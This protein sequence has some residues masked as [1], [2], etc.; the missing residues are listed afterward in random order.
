MTAAFPPPAQTWSLRHLTRKTRMHVWLAHVVLC[1]EAAWRATRLP[2]LATLAA[3]VAALFALP[4]ALPGTLRVGMLVA[5]LCWWAWVIWRARRTLL[6]S[7]RSAVRRVETDAQLTCGTLDALADGITPDAPIETH[8]L[9]ALAVV[10]LQKTIGTLPWARPALSLRKHERRYIFPLLFV[11]ALAGLWT[12]ENPLHRL[13]T[14][15]SPWATSLD[16]VTLTAWL[17]PP[18]YTGLPPRQIALPVG[19]GTEIEVPANSRLVLT[20]SGA[21]ADFRLIGPGIDMRQTAQNN[22]A[23]FNVLLVRGAYALRMGSLRPVSAWQVRITKDGAPRIAFDGAVRTS[24]TQS[25][26]I[27][28]KATDDYGITAVFLA[29]LKDNKA[30]AVA[31]PDPA[32]GTQTSGRAF[33]DLTASRHAGAGVQL[34]LVALD[35]AGTYGVSAPVSLTLP[36]RKFTHVVAQQIIAARKQVWAAPG[37]LVP[38]AARLEAVSRDPAAFGGDLTI[39]SA[40]RRSVWRLRSDQAWTEIDGITDFLWETALDV[41]A[42]KTGKDMAA[43]RAKFDQL[44]SQMQN[45]GDQ[46]KLMDQLMQEMAQ[47]MASKA[48]AD[49]QNAM[50]DPA[51]QAMGTEMLEQL[52]QELQDRMAAGDTEGARRAM[53]ALQALLENARFG[54]APGQAGSGTGQGSGSPMM[55]ALARA[56]QQ[57]QQLLTQSR[58]AG[59]SQGGNGAE[60]S[61]TLQGLAGAQAGLANQVGQAQAAAK[62]GGRKTAGAARQLAQAGEAMRAAARALEQGDVQAAARAQAQALNQLAMARQTLAR[63]Q[64]EGDGQAQGTL[65]PGAD[66]LGRTNGAASGPEL[67]LPTVAERQRAQQIR[68][69]LEERAADPSRPE[70]ERAYI[71]RLLRRF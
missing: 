34:R 31:L 63:A 65:P 38:P 10:R 39:F 37:N 26:E 30:I 44:M 42:Q 40:L 6:V 62:A 1:L 57:Q 47:F 50:M 61:D 56:I 20:A 13:G 60:P 64:A 35:A 7:A 17:R 46:Q 36:E 45:G 55:Q 12:A 25:L 3:G 32:T 59:A 14:A 52:L 28:Y 41:E 33:K 49:P 67:K 4:Q 68:A 51:G 9:W 8:A 5:L 24:L 16:T 71:L 58:A 23:D 70:A 15:F 22:L 18:D 43:L 29:V 66:P 19:S 53:E 27:K 2:L 69:L 54:M 48:N 11:G 21:D